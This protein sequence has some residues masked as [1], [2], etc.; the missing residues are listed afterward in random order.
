M[1]QPKTPTPRVARPRPDAQPHRPRSGTI[2]AAAP[3]VMHADE[4][5][6]ETY[7]H[8]RRDLGRIFFLALLLFAGIYGSQYLR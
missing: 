1:A 3:A 5:L 4:N 8:V 6:D 2:S 7:A